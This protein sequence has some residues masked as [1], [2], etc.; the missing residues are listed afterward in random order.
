[1]SRDVRVIADLVWTVIDAIPNLTTYRGQFVDANGKPFDPPLDPDGRVHPYAIVYFNGGRAY[2]RRVGG[3]PKA[4][5][6]GF[7]V[8]CAGGDDNRALAAISAVRTALTETRINP[9]DG[10]K[11]RR[12]V[13]D[14]GDPGP[15]RRDEGVSP[16]R[17]YL[18]LYF[19]TQI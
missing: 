11:P 18:P 2:S 8:T 7:Q 16:S 4:L 19:Y 9:G 5:S 13:E 12:L 3:G 14:E 1:M 15:L 6:W 17:M 10:V